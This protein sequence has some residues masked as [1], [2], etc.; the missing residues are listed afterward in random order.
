[1]IDFTFKNLV[2]SGYLGLEVFE[3]FGFGLWMDAMTFLFVHITFWWV[4]KMQ[5]AFQ[6][7]ELCP[8]AFMQDGLAVD[9]SDLE[10]T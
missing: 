4:I 6:S 10:C 5:C 2:S 7:R 3:Y 1:V 8:S 9:P